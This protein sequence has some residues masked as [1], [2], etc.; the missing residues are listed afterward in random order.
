ME[1]IY[2]PWRKAYVTASPG[3]RAAGCFLC[4]APAADRDAETLILYR[5]EYGFVIMNLYPYTSGH[6]LVAPYAH[7]AD[8]GGLPPGTAAELMALTQRC[9]R[10]IAAEYQPKGFNVGMNLG[11]PA[12]AGEPDHLHMHVVP[13]WPGDA[14]FMPITGD[15]KV[16]PETLSQTYARLLPRFR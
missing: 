2:A 6:L 9:V 7:T 8:F 16:L 13:R 1:R 10:A 4:D 12:G 3:Q 5:G 15:V 11:V 14:N